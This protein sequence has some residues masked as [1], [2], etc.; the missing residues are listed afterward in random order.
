MSMIRDDWQF[1]DKDSAFFSENG[2][3]T[4][5]QFLTDETLASCRE[6][7]DAMLDRLQPGRDPA[8]IICP[9]FFDQWIWDL[10]IEP[11]VLDMIEQQIGPNIVFW[12]SHMLCKQPGSGIVVPW[13]QDAPYWNVGGPLPCGLWIAFDDMDEDNGAMAVLPGWHKKGRLPIDNRDDQMFNEMISPDALPDNVEDNKVQYR[14]P[15][16]GMAIHDTMIPHR[17]VPNS[18][19][20]W[21]RVLV[22]R[23]MRADGDMGEKMYEDYRTGDPVARRYFLVRGEDVLNRGLERSPFEMV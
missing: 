6:E 7:L 13:H 10:A 19:D 21:R 20:R 11:K 17:S 14:I 15:A 8:D 16:G 18:S 2:Y 1:T 22:L 4:Y 23:Y 3:H 12:S 9:H 5:G